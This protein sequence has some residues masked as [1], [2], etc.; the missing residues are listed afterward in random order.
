MVQRKPLRVFCFSLCQIV[1]FSTK[2]ECSCKFYLMEVTRLITIRVFLVKE[3]SST[4]NI[5]DVFSGSFL[6]FWCCVC[7]GSLSHT[8]PSKLQSDA[9]TI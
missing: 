9:V 5:S 7:A 8:Q 3:S 1:L 2:C 6:V 4:C